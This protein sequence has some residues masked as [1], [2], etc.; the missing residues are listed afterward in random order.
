MLRN[1]DNIYLLDIAP[2]LPC[3]HA[4]AAECPIAFIY[5]RN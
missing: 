2:V 1:A 5:Y 3:V 4:V